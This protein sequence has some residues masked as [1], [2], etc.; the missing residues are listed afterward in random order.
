MELLYTVSE[1]RG[2]DEAHLSSLYGDG[3]ICT[4]SSKS[5]VAFTRTSTRQDNYR[6]RI[7]IYTVCV[8]DLN[9]PYEPH[10]I[11]ESASHV[12]SLVFSSD[13][14]QLLVVRSMGTVQLF[15]K[16]AGLHDWSV[17]HTCDWGGEDILH[18]NFFHGGIRTCLHASDVKVHGLYTEKFSAQPHKPSL[19]DHGQCAVNGFFAVTASGLLLV[20]AMTHEGNVMTEQKVVLGHT[21]DNFTVATAALA[22][23]GHIHIATWKPE[24]IKCW[25]IELK[26]IEEDSGGGRGELKVKVQAAQSFCP[27][28]SGMAWHNTQKNEGLVQVTCLRYTEMEDPNSLLVA[29]T[30]SQVGESV[31]PQQTPNGTPISSVLHMVQRYQL[32][33]QVKPLLKLF[34]PMAESTGVTTK[35]W[36]CVGEWVSSSSVITL[37]TAPRHLLPGPPGAQLPFIITAAT[38][39]S[40][41]YAINRDSMQQMS[42]HNLQGSRGNGDDQPVK[43]V[44]TDRRM[45]CLSHTWSGFSL[46]AMDSTGGLHFFTLMR[47]ADVGPQW[48]ISVILLLEFALVSGNDWWDL[49]VSTPPSSIHTLTDRL[50]DTFLGHSSPIIQHLHTRFLVMKTSMLRLAGSQQQKA[51]EARLQA[52]LTAIQ[53]LFRSLRPVTCDVATAEKNIS[54]SLQAFQESRPS[55]DTL[56]IEKALDLFCSSVNIKDCQVDPGLLQNLQPLLQFAADLALFI[57]FMLAQ[58]S[59]F[60]LARDG[61]IVH[62]LR[63]ILFVSRLWHRQNKLVLPQMFHKTQSVDV[64]AQIYKLLTRLAQILPGEPDSSLIDECVLLET[65]VVCR[66]LPLHIP[67]RGVLADMA[68][69]AATPISYEFGQ[70]EGNHVT[71]NGTQARI[72]EG[73][74]PPLQQLDPLH[75]HYLA[76][77]EPK[78]SCTRCCSVRGSWWGEG[79]TVWEQQW[80]SNCICTGHWAHCP[81][82]PTKAA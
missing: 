8:M 75:Y 48:A 47:P 30:V 27:F 14:S 16:G 3:G 61:K 80:A 66:E 22:P 49:L 5:V 45:V 60:E 25:R 57:L 55:L 21:R 42:Y 20:C 43:R 59:K 7:P 1:K 2:S 34:K 33:E 9:C 82:A 78:F 18:I 76:A 6:H 64:W 67:P 58:N 24:I 74:L 15:S 51:I 28:R 29:L 53:Q 38:A 69:S 68:S 72:L 54:V 81:V 26:M 50:T 46:L 19:V 4:I 35:E 63:E 41:I 12:S 39:D 79:E 23:S 37:G 62:S 56:D 13:G 65:Q 36:V 31:Q 71:N 77:Q 73:A 11:V 44:A 52:Q 10:V 32:Q 70:S 40:S 17:T